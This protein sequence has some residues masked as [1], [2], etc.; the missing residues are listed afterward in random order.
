MI[1]FFID[2]IVGSLIIINFAY[3]WVSYGFQ[4]VQLGWFLAFCYHVHYMGH[5]YII[6][7]E[8]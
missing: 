4:S 3:N 6:W 2:I 8:K 1:R 5:S 7:K